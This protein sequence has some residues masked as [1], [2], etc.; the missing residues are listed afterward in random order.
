MMTHAEISDNIG[1]RTHFLEMLYVQGQQ[2][3]W[4]GQD[5]NPH[6]PNTAS[7]QSWQEGWEQARRRC[8]VHLE[9]NGRG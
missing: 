9:R 1:E 7:Y 4:F 8:T 3:F 5:R 6:D 2:A